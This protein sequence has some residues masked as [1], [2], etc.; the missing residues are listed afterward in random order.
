[1][2][3]KTLGHFARSLAGFL[4]TAAM[5]GCSGNSPVSP[6][7]AIVK[8]L[9]S[10][11]D[12]PN[13]AQVSF[14]A[15]VCYMNQENFQLAFAGAPDTVTA[16]QNCEIFKLMAGHQVRVQFGDIR[17]NDSIEVNGQRHAN[18]DVVAQRLRI[19]SSDGSC[20]YDLAFRDSILSI[21]YTAGTFTVYGRTESIVTDSNTIIWGRFTS[22]ESNALSNTD[23]QGNAHR[24]RLIKDHD[25]Q[26]VFSDLQAGDVVEVKAKIVDENTLLAVKINVAN[27]STKE[28]V[29]F[30]AGLAGI[31]VSERTVTFENLDWQGWICPKAEL[32]DDEGTALLLEDFVVGDQVSVKGFPT[33]DGT[34]KIC[35]MTLISPV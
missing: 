8:S 29:T 10:G 17:L 26:Y 9:E 5:F 4:L 23:P 12:C 35:V 22:R 27:C 34:L 31:N 19:M 25:V 18:G 32:V 14:S 7:G 1:M 20:G 28:C 3:E 11:T 2:F 30:A 33:A 24:D 16:L 6:I 15:R 13:C 21:D